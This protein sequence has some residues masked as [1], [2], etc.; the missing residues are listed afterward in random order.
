M[1]QVT[2]PVHM[3]GCQLAMATSLP[4]PLQKARLAPG[5][6]VR[7]WQLLHFCCI[8]ADGPH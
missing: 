1:Q 2:E 5:A 7:A 3:E 6:Q 4:S 8:P